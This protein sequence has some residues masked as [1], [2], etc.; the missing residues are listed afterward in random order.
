MTEARS[1][2]DRVV[3]ESGLAHVFAT[4]TI[5]RACERAGV[6]PDTL[7]PRDMEKVAPFI[8]KALSVFLPPSEVE[9]SM[10]RI[11]MLSGDDPAPGGRYA[12]HAQDPDPPPPPSMRRP[13]G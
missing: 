2:L 9:R 10:D 12:Q 11:L 8:E 13:S 3:A 1:F 4:K 6:A 5:R 7:K